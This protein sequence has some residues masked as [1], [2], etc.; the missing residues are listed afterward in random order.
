MITPIKIAIVEYDVSARRKLSDLINAHLG[1]DCVGAWEN[2]ADIGLRIKCTK[3]HVLLMDIELKGK[4]NGIQATISLKEEFS[5]LK[6]VIHT[7]CEENEQVF[8]AIQAGATGYLLKNTPPAKLLEGLEDAANGNA[9][10]TP[11]IAHKIITWLPKMIAPPKNSPS[12]SALSERQ[13]EVMSGII[14]GKGYKA[15]A[16]ELY[17]SGDTVRFHIKNIYELLHVH[18]KYEL[19]MKYRK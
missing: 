18:S 9:A 15:I 11:S 4:M 12:V 17:I 14:D 8:Q 16:E 3:P 13:K 5:D 1:F 19:I 6:I 2:A 7:S 10:L